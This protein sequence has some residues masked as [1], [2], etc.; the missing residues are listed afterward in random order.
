MDILA[1]IKV[2]VHCTGGSKKY[3][4]TNPNDKKIVLNRIKFVNESSFI[5]KLK[6]ESRTIT[7]FVG[8]RY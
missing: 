5:V 7:L 2:Y 1:E 4:I 6:Y 8:I 3:A